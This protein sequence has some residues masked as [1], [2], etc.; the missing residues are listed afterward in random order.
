MRRLAGPAL[1]AVLLC[2]IAAPA[3]AEFSENTI[4][5][6]GSAVITSDDGETYEVDAE[7]ETVEVPRDGEAAWEGSISTVTHNHSGEVV[8]EVGP[9]GEVPLGDWGPSENADDESS[10]SGVKELPAI[11]EQ[12]PAGSYD[13]SGFHEGDEGRCAGSVTVE[14]DGSP[15]DTPLGIANAVLTILTG[16]LLVG[17]MR[18]AAGKP[19]FRGRPV[20]G[21]IAGLLFGLF[22]AVELVFLKVISSGSPLLIALPIIFL[23]VGIA[24]ALA[25]PFGRGGHGGPGEPPPP[26]PAPEPAAVA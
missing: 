16:I 9:F 8:L 13:V 5:C 26:E 25:A 24:G 19:A 15:F 10:A 21:A 23:I 4:G 12:V 6:A 2:G 18:A 17:S 14:I 3:A 22:L 11:L 1:V 20:L 7:D